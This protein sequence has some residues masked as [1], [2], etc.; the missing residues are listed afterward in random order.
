MYVLYPHIR[1]VMQ[2]SLIQNIPTKIKCV[3]NTYTIMYIYTMN[4]VYIYIEDGWLANRNSQL[5]NC[6]NP[7]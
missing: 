6:D 2:P 7:H 5:M 3:F 1:M 4:Y